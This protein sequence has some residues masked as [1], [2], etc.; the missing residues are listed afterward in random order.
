VSI[1]D[2]VRQWLNQHWQPEVDLRQF[3]EV[4]VDAGWL[5]PTWSRDWFGRELSVA[6]AAVVGEEFERVGAPGRADRSNLHAR[7]IY[8]LGTD[9][10]RGTYLRDLLTGAVTGCLLYSEPGAGSDLASLCTSAVRDGERWRVN[11]QK[12][13]TSGA[14]RAAYGLLAARTDSTVPKHAGITFFV[15]PM[16]QPGVEVRPI[17]QITGDE[18]FN[19]VFLTDAFVD[20]ANRLG[21]VGA[22]WQTLMTALG[23]ERSVMGAR[24]VGSRADDPRYIGTDDDLIGLARR[25]RKLD[26]A[27]TVAALADV[28]AA[29]AAARLNTARYVAEGR[30]A[31]PASLSVGKLAM[32][33]ILHDTARVR[34]DI[35]G[36]ATLLDGHAEPPGDGELANFF[37]LDAY[38]TSIGGGTD[39]IQ[40]NI[41]G[42]RILGLPKEDDP[43]KY[44]PFNEVRK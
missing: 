22:G 8:H 44:R 1:R 19:E 40:R 35:V 42:E 29:R 17:V 33:R 27:A 39:Q 6:D 38:F 24:G 37:T 18:H 23:F 26:D 12:V 32:S 14:Q 20:D 5:V 36:A 31:D 3:R 2:D 15:L 11:G 9:L 25:H 13:W 41:I 21:E 30:A 34:R 10:L 43:S 16:N 4:A 28:Y 7:I